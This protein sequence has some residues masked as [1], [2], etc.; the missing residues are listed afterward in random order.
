MGIRIV[1]VV[2]EG[3]DTWALSSPRRL[4][5]QGKTSVLSEVKDIRYE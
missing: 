4:I 3:I 5:I 2:I 1:D